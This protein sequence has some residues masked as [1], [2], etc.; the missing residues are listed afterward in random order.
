MSERVEEPEKLVP[1]WELHCPVCRR[2]SWD[3]MEDD[4]SGERCPICGQWPAKED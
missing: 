2:S 1:L 3:G 4:E